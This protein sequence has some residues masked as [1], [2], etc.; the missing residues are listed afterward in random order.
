MSW[1][2]EEQAKLKTEMPIEN[3]YPEPLILKPNVIV[4]ITIDFSM[5][6]KVWD[7]GEGKVK[8]IIPVMENGKPKTFWLNKRNPLYHQIIEAGRNGQ[9]VFKIL[10]TGDKKDTRYSIVK[11]A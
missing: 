7:D 11:D 3:Q 10:Q 9:T 1:L 8:S 2:D 5:P 4:T 6:F